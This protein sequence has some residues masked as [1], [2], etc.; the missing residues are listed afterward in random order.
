MLWTF[1][2]VKTF[3]WNPDILP[4]G[5]SDKLIY[6]KIHNLKSNFLHQE[7]VFLP[8]PEVVSSFPLVIPLS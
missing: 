8:D 1:R 5:T 2:P 6:F 4:S 3:Y 7:T